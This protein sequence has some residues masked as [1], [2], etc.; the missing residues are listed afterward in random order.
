ME[1]SANCSNQRPPPTPHRVEPHNL[2]LDQIASQLDDPSSPVAQAVDGTANYLIAA[3]CSVTSISAAPICSSPIIAQAQ[4]EMSA[5][6]YG[7][8]APSQLPS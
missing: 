4:S 3:M 6:P 7:T 2:T 8:G 1:H 5:N